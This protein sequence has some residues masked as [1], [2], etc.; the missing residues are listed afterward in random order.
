MWTEIDLSHLNLKMICFVFD[1]L[2][3]HT[4]PEKAVNVTPLLPPEPALTTDILLFTDLIMFMY[5]LNMSNCSA[6]SSLTLTIIIHI[7]ILTYS[8][9]IC[10][11]GSNFNKNK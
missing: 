1:S 10:S 6:F 4:V 9:F 3:V 11:R 8:Y 7:I 2:N 5:S